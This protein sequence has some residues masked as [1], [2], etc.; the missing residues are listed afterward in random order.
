MKLKEAQLLGIVALIAVAIILLCMWG[1]GH[2]SENAAVVDEQAQ[3]AAGTDVGPGDLAE[4]LAREEPSSPVAPAEGTVVT[5]GGAQPP[6]A[7]LTEDAAIRA[8]IEKLEPKD[9]PLAPKADLATPLGPSVAPEPTPAARVHVV[10]SGDNFEKLSQKYYGT[11]TKAALIQ[12]ANKGVDSRRLKIG[13]KLTIPPLPSAASA[14]PKSVAVAGTAVPATPTLSAP[15]E[16]PA[17]VHV[18]QSGD[19]FERLSVKYY[20]TRTRAAL[21]QDANRAADS[22]RLRIGTKLTIPPL[23]SAASSTATA[24]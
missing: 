18:V 17:R 24:L 15:T 11:R 16:A 10:Q 13:M 14:A 5:V 1:G 21:I 9:I 3:S 4:E 2:K 6:P 12:E 19:T 8:N 22:R 7:P 20:G 23:P